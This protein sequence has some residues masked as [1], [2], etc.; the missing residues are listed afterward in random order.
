MSYRQPDACGGVFV[1]VAR[2]LAR[3]T[4]RRSFLC[5]LGVALVGGMVLPTLPVNR[6]GSGTAQAA[7]FG[8]RAQSTDE[9]QCNYWRY[10]AIGGNLCSCCGGSAGSCPPGTFSPATGWVGTCLNPQ[11]QQVYLIMYRDCCGKQACGRCGCLSSEK[12]LPVYRAQ[13][14]DEYVWCFGTEQM[15]Y[16]CTVASMIGKG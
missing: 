6:S 11:D 8:D 7:S 13:S 4:S 3:R 5:R 15:T 16:H 1:E 12:Q 9:T 2:F 10:C 14:S